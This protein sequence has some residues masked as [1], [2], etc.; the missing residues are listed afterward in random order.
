MKRYG[1]VLNGKLVKLCATLAVA[2]SSQVYKPWHTSCIVY[3]FTYNAIGVPIEAEE[4]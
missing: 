4:I 2:M 1:I 3:E